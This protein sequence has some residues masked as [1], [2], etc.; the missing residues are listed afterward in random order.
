MGVAQ[1]GAPL[2]EFHNVSIARGE[3]R[4]LDSLNL[5]IASG[6]HVAILGPNGSGKSTL[7]KAITRELY[8]LQ[9]NGAA[10]V[11]I[12]G[13]EAW[14]VF[15]LRPHLGIVTNDLM[16]LCTRNYS[17]R[18]IVLSGFFSSVGIWPNHVVTAAMEKKADEVIELLEIAGLAARNVDELSSGE[19]RRVLIARALVHSPEAL[20]LDEPTASLDFRAVRELREIL[21]KITVAGTSMIL[22][23]HHLEDIIPEIHRVVILK[24]GRI[25]RDGP[26][27]DVLTSEELSRLFD[28]PAQVLERGGYYHLV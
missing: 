17:A 8:P 15:E 14:N 5:S 10:S 18:E 11:R 23:T 4:G 27:K 9:T 13:R 12:L 2:I 16:L 22:V 7:I 24:D 1:K 21:R 20:V 6:E 3:K 28:L 25:V 26:K 19:A